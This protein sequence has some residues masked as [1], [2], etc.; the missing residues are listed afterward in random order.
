MNIIILGCVAGW[1]QQITTVDYH[2]LCKI[3]SPFTW[4]MHPSFQELVEECSAFVKISHEGRN[5]TQHPSCLTAIVW[6]SGQKSMMEYIY[7]KS[8]LNL[9]YILKLLWNFDL[10]GKQYRSSLK[11]LLRICLSSAENTG[12]V[13]RAN[14]ICTALLCY[15]KELAMIKPGCILL[16]IQ[17]YILFIGR[18]HKPGRMSHY[19]QL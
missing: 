12:A 9:N 2:L 5:N 14:G 19:M 1:F 18:S 10:S 3:S 6:G 11:N 7:I 4:D 8:P 13:H 15:S 17:K 16:D